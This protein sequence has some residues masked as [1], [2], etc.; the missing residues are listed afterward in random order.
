LLTARHA[1]RLARVRFPDADNMMEGYGRVH[2][3][4]DCRSRGSLLYC[5]AMNRNR[6][7]I[8]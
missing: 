1:E 3:F 7:R 2:L 8:A 6:A 4:T 5:A